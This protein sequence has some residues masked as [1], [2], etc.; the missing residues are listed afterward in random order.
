MYLP[1]G[2]SISTGMV[3]ML[4]GVGLLVQWFVIYAAIRLALIHDRATRLRQEIP[5]R[6]HRAGALA[7]TRA[8]EHAIQ[9]AAAAI[10][11]NPDD[12][13]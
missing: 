2:Q 4:L 3:W 1:A 11:T 6:V 10:Q 7:E 13:P 8:G 9:E 12:G 5:G